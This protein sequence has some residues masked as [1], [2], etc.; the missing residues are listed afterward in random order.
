MISKATNTMKCCKNHFALAATSALALLLAASP[1]SATSPVG[2]SLNLGAGVFE[3]GLGAGIGHREPVDYTGFGLN[4]ELGYGIT[5]VLELRMRSGLRFG[6]AGRVTDADRYGRPVETETYN[7]GYDSLA[8]P[9]VGLRYNLVRGGTAEIALDGKIY[10]PISGDFGIL[11]GVPVAL[12]LGSR[13]RFDTGVFVPIVFAES[14]YNEIS[15][16]LHVWI[17]LQAGSFVGPM[18]GVIFHSEGGKRVPFGIGA[19]TALSYD[20]DLRFWLLFEDISHEGGGKN[21]GAGVGLYV[22]F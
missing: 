12:H 9:E 6:S 4:F 2:R 19:G 15:I 17:K 18:T 13:L 3:L 5:P 7:L 10:L 21:L 14:T 1:A 20:A 22:T 11:L 16:P 8:N